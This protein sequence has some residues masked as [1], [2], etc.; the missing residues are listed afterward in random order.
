M[1]DEGRGQG[2]ESKYPE[3]EEGLLEYPRLRQVEVFQAA[4]EG[5]QVLG[6]RDPQGYADGVVFV[7]QPVVAILQLCDGRHSLFDI[8]AEA[9]RRLGSL[10][11]RAQLLEILQ[12]LD[13]ALLLE[14]PRFAA[15]Q[16]EIV[17]AFCEA[18]ARPARLAGLSYPE[19][20]AELREHLA[21]FFEAA[22]GP[23]EAPPSLEAPHLTGLVVPHIDYSRG[24]TCYAWGYRELAGAL[25]VDNWVILGTVHA[26]IDQPF[27][28]TRKAFETPLGTLETDQELL[29]RLLAR[30]GR[31]YLEDEIA[32]R[33]EHS[34]E[35]QTVFLRHLLPPDRPV[36]ILPILCGSLHRYVEEETSPAEAAEL[37]DFLE[38]L[39]RTLAQSGGRTVVLASAD[40]AHVGPQFDDPRPVTRWQLRDG[41]AADR[42]M[43]A[44]VEA[45]DAEGFFQAVALGGN[46]RRVCGL[47]PIYAM[48]RVLEGAKGRLLR[49]GQWPDPDGTVTFAALAMY[50]QGETPAATGE[51]RVKEGRI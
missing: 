7:P 23:R 22:E 11:F 13:Q 51:T 15:H 37:T 17:R 28:L 48:L 33:G 6:L 43:L 4:H 21:S 2:N 49:Y 18:S 34:I 32:H 50:A 46:P 36:R 38:D 3:G 8:Q 31:R 29:D 19:D 20:A 47:P 39:R 14:S 16:A 10:L 40:L 26:P 42:R 27:A 5:R 30:V 25:P 12:V 41:E 35:L 24:G 45:G 1:A 9:S 44:P